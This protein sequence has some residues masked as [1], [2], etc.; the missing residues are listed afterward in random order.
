MPTPNE[1]REVLYRLVQANSPYIVER[2]PGM[3][4]PLPSLDA[5]A[6]LP[7]PAGTRNVFFGDEPAPQPTG[8]AWA[9]LAVRHTE[10]EG[11][12]MSR[13]TFDVRGNAQ[14][15]VYTPV[16]RQSAEAYGFDLAYLVAK[17]LDPR[18]KDPP[19]FADGTP[20]YLLGSKIEQLPLAEN[21]KWYRFTIEAPFRYED[22]R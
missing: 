11:V 5:A 10:R 3:A 17:V 16:D 18:P 7:L 4:D 1:A 13:R 19:R 20:L 21:S 9:T 15:T 12:S 6:A 8:A 2:H 22:R 14:V